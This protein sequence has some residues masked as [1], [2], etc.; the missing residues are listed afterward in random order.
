MKRRILYVLFSMV[1]ILSFGLTACQPAAEEAPAAP[2]AEEPAAVEEGP[3][4]AIK[5][6][7]ES[8]DYGGELKAIEAVDE[9]TV[10]FTLCYPDPALPGKL[11]LAAFG[12]A[13]SEDLDKYGGDSTKLSEDPNGTGPYMFKEWVKGDHVTF[14]ANPNYWGEKA[15]A[16]TLIVRWSDQSAQRLLELQSGTVD[17]IDNLSPEDIEAVKSSTEIKIVERPAFNIMYLG[18]NSAIPPF[19][20]VKVRQAVAMAIDKQRIIDNYYPA[21][22][23]VAEQFTPDFVIPGH[24][25]GMKWYDYDPEAAKALLAEAGFPDGFETTISFRLVMRGYLPLADKVTQEMQAQLAEVGIDA[26]INQMESTAFLDA[27]NLGELPLFLLGWTGDFADATNW[28]DVHF[29]PSQDDFGPVN[30]DMVELQRQAG[31]IA[32]IAERQKIYGQVN[33]MIKDDVPV[34]P[35]AHGGSALAFKTNVEGAYASPFG[36]SEFYRMGNGTDQL[37]FMQNAEPGATFAWDETDGESLGMGRQMFN[38]LT[39]AELDGTYPELAKS[40]DV[41]PEATEYVFHLRD[42]VKYHDGAKFDANDVVAFFTAMW[43]AKSPNHVGRTGAFEYFI[44]AFAQ[45]LNA[46]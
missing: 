23:S 44:T 10:K 7:A 11:S 12:I 3:F 40:W 29:D 15:K 27:V 38:T 22:S 18:M 39:A 2:A 5:T 24:T 34:V 36:M 33:Q 25:K 14:E 16:K 45:F 21:G 35:V 1:L 37:V 42:D 26:K 31:K 41:N 43:D 28:F 8:C 4:E 46:E 19:D 13:N 30:M 6:E 17:G 20:N 9:Y 32:D